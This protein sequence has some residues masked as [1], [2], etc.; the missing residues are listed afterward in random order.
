MSRHK[1]LPGNVTYASPM[2]SIILGLIMLVFPWHLL[3][4]DIVRATQSYI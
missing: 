1:R 4:V 2:Q 3:M